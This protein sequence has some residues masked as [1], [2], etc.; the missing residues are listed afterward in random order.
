MIDQ[1]R[2]FRLRQILNLFLALLLSSFST[3]NMKKGQQRDTAEGVDNDDDAA[4]KTKENQIA[5]AYE[6]LQRWAKFFAVRLRFWHVA[7]TIRAQDNDSVSGG[8]ALKA[9]STRDT[10][11]DLTIGVNSD[12]EQ[13]HQ[14]AL[15]VD[16]AGQ[17]VTHC[18]DLYQ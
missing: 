7:A 13:S 14:P 12:S 16:F 1:C 4:A 2:W 3:E 9:A 6:R 11:C 18:Y 10:A 5:A 17:Q 15:L 8:G